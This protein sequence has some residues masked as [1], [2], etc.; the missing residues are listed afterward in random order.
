MKL[1]VCERES[2]PAWIYPSV[3]SHFA[4]IG[5]GVDIP[6]LTEKD[7]SALAE[8]IKD[9]VTVKE[10]SS[11]INSGCDIGFSHD[12]PQEVLMI[13]PLL[14]KT[15]N[16]IPVHNRWKVA[17]DWAHIRTGKRPNSEVLASHKGLLKTLC[18]FAAVLAANDSECREQAD[19]VVVLAE[20][21]E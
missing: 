9:V 16:Q 14:V 17:E 7:L 12:S 19:L 15:L 20:P 6:A 5:M 10:S 11:W 8:A 13:S 3:S 1:V 2:I 21:C 18:E 4:D